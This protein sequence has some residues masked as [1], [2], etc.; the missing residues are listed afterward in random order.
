MSAHL[1][2]LANAIDA[3]LLDVDGTLVDSNDAHARSWVRA[4][5]EAGKDVPFE[6]VRPLLGMGSDKLLPEIDRSLG[7]ETEPG[8]TIARRRGEIFKAD[9][10]DGIQ[11]TRGT[12]ELLETLKSRGVRCVVATSAKPDEL[13]VLL[14]IANVEAFVDAATT[15]DDVAQSKPAPDVV[16]IALEKV[17]VPAN[18]AVM[19]GDTRFDIE[20][21]RNAGI[22]T[23]ALR[24]GGSPDADFAGAI[25][26]FDDPA[27][28][29][30][31]LT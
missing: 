5:N 19:L 24:C 18:R 4:F 28:L 27:D 29:A 31:R 22:G 3:V 2:E 15:T 21:A 11:A 10:I 16:T 9:Y 26:V 17:G 8:K 20:S 30:R 13:S 23:I 12:R 6:K 14:R 1:P 25:A 7:A